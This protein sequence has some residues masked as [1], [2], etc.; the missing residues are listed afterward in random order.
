MHGFERFLAC[1]ACGA[2]LVTKTDD[3]PPRLIC[4]AC[5][6]QLPQS[7][8]P[9]LLAELDRHAPGVLVLA[10]LVTMPLMLLALTPWLE[11]RPQ[12]RSVPAAQRHGVER[13]R[14]DP[15]TGI[16]GRQMRGNRY[17]KP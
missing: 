2:R 14:W 13:S 16:V 3:R 12:G 9:P 1:P 17:G 5:G 4:A 8:M 11:H 7:N 10:L 6:K 15:R